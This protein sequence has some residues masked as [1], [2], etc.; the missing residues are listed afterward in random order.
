MRVCVDEE[1]RER[2]FEVLRWYDVELE[3]MGEWSEIGCVCAER[4]R[5][6]VGEEER[7]SPSV[8]IRQSAKN[9][10]AIKQSLSEKNEIFKLRN[11]FLSTYL[12]TV[13]TVTKAF[14][15]F[16]PYFF[17]ILICFQIYLTELN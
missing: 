15:D 2:E 9:N 8:N 1:E 10:P 5:A 16:R 6:C 14:S 3:R 11:L 12:S 17:T 13:D 4:E 7:E